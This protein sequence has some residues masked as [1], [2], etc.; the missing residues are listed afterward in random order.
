V[1]TVGLRNF[2]GREIEMEA[3]DEDWGLVQQTAGNLALYFLDDDVTVEDGD[4]FSNPDYEDVQIPMRFR[5]SA[6]YEG[7]PVI[8]I[9]LP[10]PKT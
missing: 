5:D 1:I 2:I 10:A 8:A 7:T 4:T 3:R 6:R 9:T